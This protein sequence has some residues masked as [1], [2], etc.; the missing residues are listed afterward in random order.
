[1]IQLFLECNYTTLITYYSYFII[2]RGDCIL[3]C[4]EK[5]NRKT[6][7]LHYRYHAGSAISE[8]SQS[9]GALL[10][11]RITYTCY[12]YSLHIIFYINV[13]EV[14]FSNC[15][16]HSNFETFS[17]NAHHYTIEILKLE[18]S[19]QIIITNGAYSMHSFFSYMTASSKT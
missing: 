13:A 5:R 17:R 3:P 11:Y 12:K 6:Y 15:E 9:T 19:P 1:M 4:D 18:D 8:D 14:A 2:R 10:K 16:N 7:T